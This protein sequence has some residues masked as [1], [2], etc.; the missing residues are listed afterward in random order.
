MV[1]RNEYKKEQHRFV[2][3]FQRELKTAALTKRAKQ[4]MYDVKVFNNISEKGLLGFPKNYR[5]LPPDE[6]ADNA[7]VDVVLCRSQNLH[8]FEIDSRL[9]AVGRAGAGVNNIPVPEMTEAGV[10][11]F[12]TPGAN[13]NAVRELTLAGM[14]IA[15][16]NIYKATRYVDKLDA[17][18]AQLATQVEKGKK[19]FVGCEL[20][21]RPLGV[22]G[23]GSIGRSVAEAALGLDMRVVGYD[24]KITIEGA[25]QLARGID[26]AR[27]VEDLVS[28]C[29]FISLHVPL[30]DMTRGMV[31]KK[32]LSRVL[33]G[34]VII[35]LSRDSIVDDEAMAAALEAGRVSCYVTDF[36]SPL[37]KDRENVVSL[38]HLGASTQE[39]EENC[40]RMVVEQVKDYV[41]NG[42]IRNSVNF[43]SIYMDRGTEHRL[44]VVNRNVPNMV[45]QISTLLADANLN[46]HDMINQSR[47][48][49]ACT[50]TDTDSSVN[51]E[52][53]EAISAVEGVLTAR[54]L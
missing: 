15:A 31:N 47:G 8:D 6:A 2:F 46:I 34:A 4:A 33:P 10:A 54:L 18:S 3:R 42:N 44:F 26:R 40:A 45:G 43:P 28:R 20:S 30:N 38:P 14:I 27:N 22:V 1:F 11:V 21:N 52:V 13:A 48:D 9:K 29:E 41:D 53:F 5:I 24:P 39:A 7:P 35:N 37:L 23:L 19:Q 16:R 36:P 17:Q 25:W 49:I 32:L 12:N 50:I 51:S